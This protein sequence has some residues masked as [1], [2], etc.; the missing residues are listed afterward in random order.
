MAAADDRTNPNELHH[1]RP[2][3][4]DRPDGPMYPPHPHTTEPSTS[5]VLVVLDPDDPETTLRA[6]V[7]EADPVVTAF[8]LLLVYPTAEYEARRRARHDAGAPGPYTIDHLAE[9]AR[10][11]A[12]RL[13]RAYLADAAGVEALGAVGGTR[14]CVRRA[15]RDTEC[16]RVYVAEDSRSIWQRLLGVERLSMELSEM[17]PDVVSVVSLEEVA[18]PTLDDPE[19]EVVLDSRGSHDGSHRSGEDAA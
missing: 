14:D 17:L 7:R 9:E 2:T 4:H 10:R 5:H 8:H 6:V 19:C 11:V 13:G 3:T 15:A 12:E 18:D 1:D 16:S